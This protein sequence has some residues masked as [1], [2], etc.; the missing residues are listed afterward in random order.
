MMP[1]R[2][3]P[4]PTEELSYFAVDYDSLSHSVS[5]SQGMCKLVNETT[6]KMGIM[7][8]KAIFGTT[9]QFFTLSRIA[10]NIKVIGK[11]HSSTSTYL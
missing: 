7:L 8:K 6:H 2:S 1:A 10:N 9:Q 11:L 4:N 5:V 3:I